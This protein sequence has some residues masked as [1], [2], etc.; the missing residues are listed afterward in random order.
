VAGSEADHAAG[1]LP[2]LPD[3]P[4][5][6]SS[7][8]VVPRPIA[9][10][11][12]VLE[13]VALTHPIGVSALA[14]QLGVAKST[15]HRNLKAL[16]GL[17]YIFATGNPPQWLPTLR[18]FEVGSRADRLAIR[19]LAAPPLRTLV[20]EIGESAYASLMEGRHIVVIEK[21]DAAR[22]VRAHVELGFVGPAHISSAGLAM[23][24]ASAPGVVESFLAGPLERYTRSSIVDPDE[25]RAEL[26]R[27]RERGYGI[28]AGYRREEIATIAVAV[29]DGAGRPVVGVSCSTPMHRFDKAKEVELAAAVRRAGDALG[30]SLAGT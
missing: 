9:T 8:L 4:T 5:G 17:G 23:L 24:A 11:F 28:S 25:L 2:T 3:P 6:A 15:T 21:V 13:A 22:A 27:T 26:D 30:R 29:C 7:P 10:A 16:E 18:A 1:D 19:E 14:R 20:D 12:Q